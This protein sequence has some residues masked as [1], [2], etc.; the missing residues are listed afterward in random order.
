M[1]SNLKR[2]LPQAHNIAQ[3][4]D[5]IEAV[6]DWTQD[7]IYDQ[8]PAAVEDL[9][10]YWLRRRFTELRPQVRALDKLAQDVDVNSIETIDDVIPLCFPHTMLKAYSASD[11]EKR[12]FD[13]MNRWLSTMTK[14]DL[15][16]VDVR[17]VE[18][19]DEWLNRISAATPLIPQ[20]S[21]GTSGKISIQPKTAVEGNHLMVGELRCFLPYRDEPGLDP[22]R[23]D[24]TLVTPWIARSGPHHVT[25]LQ[26]NAVKNI[27]GGREEG[28]VTLGYQKMSADALWLSGRLR[29][30][31]MTGEELKLTDKE[32]E[33][34]KQIAK[35]SADVAS[36]AQMDRFIDQAVTRL[37]G[38]KV[39]IRATW[40]RIYDMAVACKERGVRP[41]YAP[42]SM[43]ATG[44]GAKNWVFPEGWRELISEYFPLPTIEMYGMSEFSAISRLCPEGHWHAP[45]WGVSWIVDPKT[46]KPLPRKGVQT[47]R[48]VC[49]DLLAESY[50]AGTLSGDKLTM[51]WDGGCACGRKGPYAEMDVRRFTEV[52]GGDDKISCSK[53]ADAYTDLV[54]YTQ[55]D[56]DG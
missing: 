3:L 44:G 19:L 40:Q 6:L 34:A 39:Y 56:V 15:S 25:M 37:K 4:Y 14:H 12:R 20:L 2:A 48:Y 11:L 24:A 21:S 28:V 29:R 52:E 23:G 47:G 50:W 42:G 9:Q 1:E 13:R 46:S 27:F 33:L 36:P 55:G 18:S 35:E 45:L 26:T 32:R 49:F 43:A 41:D 22:F 16:H 38:K 53:T 30:A 8:D 31:Q 51:H 10:L 5:D 7:E 54:K 17:G